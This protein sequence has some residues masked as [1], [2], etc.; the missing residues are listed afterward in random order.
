MASGVDIASALAALAGVASAGFAVWGGSRWSARAEKDERQRL[1]TEVLGQPPLGPQIVEAL[2]RILA[3]SG[4]SPELRSKVVQA[5]VFASRYTALPPPTGAEQH[6]V[7]ADDSKPPEPASVYDQLLI[8]DYALGLTQARRAFNVSMVFSILGG[9]VLVIGISLAIFRADTG[10]QV[11]GAAI[12]SAAGVLT[13]GLSQLFR[14]QSAKALKHLE[15]QATELRKDVR[16]QTNAETAQRLLDDVA[17]VEL[18][19]RLQAALIL[20]FTGATL[21]DLGPVPQ[22][23][24]VHVIGTARSAEFA[25]KPDASSG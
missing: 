7:P 14:G 9:L 6:P 11:A 15:T 4:A 22:E 8:N 16:A 20:Q 17:D 1:S 12:T 24:P 2:G 10:G 21:P 5:L 23:Q 18:R 19:G 3:E 13:S 25:E